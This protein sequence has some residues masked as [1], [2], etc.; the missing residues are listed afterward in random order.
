MK[1]YD[2][3]TLEQQVDAFD[4]QVEMLLQDILENH[5]GFNDELNGDDLQA[6]IDKA[7]DRAEAMR[8]PWFAHE[9]I[10]DTCREEIEGMA[11]TAVEE[12]LYS[13]GDEH[14]VKGIVS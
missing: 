13:E 8:T 14:V 10:M 5:I 11:Q 2:Q 1:T 4:R 6:R 3:L 12:S 7:I 9:Y